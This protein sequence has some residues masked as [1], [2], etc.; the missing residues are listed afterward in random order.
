MD[1][2]EESKRVRTTDY[3]IFKSRD[4]NR[5]I[6][7]A[8]VQKIMG[9]IKKLNLCH[10]K[11]MLVNEHMEVIDGQH[12][13]EACK[14]MKIEVYYVVVDFK[15]KSDEAMIDINTINKHWI[16][17]DYIKHYASKSGSQF[18]SYRFLKK[19]HEQNPQ[20]SSSVCATIITN[21]G[22]GYQKQLR[23][24]TFKPGKS[25]PYEVVSMLKQ[26][27]EI[28]PF[29]YKINFIRAF[30]SIIRSNEYNHELHYPKMEKHSRS[31]REQATTV[32]YIDMF[33]EYINKGKGSRTPHIKF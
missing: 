18:D 14:R 25:D 22:N 27:K 21:T 26:Y 4:D 6:D 9:K 13:L 7:E 28:M 2:T 24:G 10:A 11:P 23:N 1:T 17:D 5:N 31:C 12:Q 16:L 30:L 19:F 33:E 3:T 20:F 15:G 29:A 32:N 8:Q